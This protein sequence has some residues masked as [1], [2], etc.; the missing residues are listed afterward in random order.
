MA[1]SMADHFLKEICFQI[2]IIFLLQMHRSNPIKDQNEHLSKAQQEETIIEIQP[3]QLSLSTPTNRFRKNSDILSLNKTPT[4]GKE[5][6]NSVITYRTDSIISK[7]PTP[8]LQVPQ[9]RTEDL[10]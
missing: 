2:P 3:T 10:I 5:R 9:N 1:L 7:C 4:T 6:I 8:H